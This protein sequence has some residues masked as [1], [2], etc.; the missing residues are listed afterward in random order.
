MVVTV[1]SGSD[2]VLRCAIENGRVGSLACLINEHV[3]RVGMGRIPPE[4]GG[5]LLVAVVLEKGTSFPGNSA[6]RVN[7]WGCGLQVIVRDTQHDLS[8]IVE[9]IELPEE[10]R[11][12][13]M[14]EGRPPTCC[15]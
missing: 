8:E 7:W 6:K 9:A 13:A 5:E 2:K 1:V 11:L 3:A 4:I 10:T 15:F 12:A 14:V